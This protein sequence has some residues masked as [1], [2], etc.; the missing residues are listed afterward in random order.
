MV[1]ESTEDLC[2]LLQDVWNNLPVTYLGSLSSWIPGH[3]RRMEDRDHVTEGKV[4]FW[5]LPDP[6]RTECFQV[7]LPSLHGPYNQNKT[8]QVI[9]RKS[10]PFHRAVT[11]M[12]AIIEFPAGSAQLDARPAVSEGT[13]K[14]RPE[15]FC[16]HQCNRIILRPPTH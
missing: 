7:E 4:I 11:G 14:G 10:T 12:F 9:S 15:S 1:L 3:R 5:I 13:L 8:T 2:L 6:E 16:F